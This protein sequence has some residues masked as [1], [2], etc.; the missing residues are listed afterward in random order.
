MSI[1]FC[2]FKSLSQHTPHT[3][4]IALPS[5]PLVCAKEPRR[6]GLFDVVL[7]PHDHSLVDTSARYSMVLAQK[8]QK[9]T[10][11][12]SHAPDPFRQASYSGQRSGRPFQRGWEHSS[13]MPNPVKAS[14]VA[15]PGQGFPNSSLRL[16]PD[17]VAKS[18]DRRPT[19]PHDGYRTVWGRPVFAHTC[20]RSGLSRV[21]SRR[22]VNFWSRFQRSRGSNPNTGPG[23]YL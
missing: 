8:T 13:S 17:L 18:A 7:L 1:P 19:C 22:Q 14:Q 12:T 11:I 23:V 4:P 15:F 9:E 5:S 21:F 20:L 10:F 16:S 6:P 3:S 2:P